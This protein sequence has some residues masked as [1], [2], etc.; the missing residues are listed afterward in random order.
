MAFKTATR[1]RV[2]ARLALVGMSKSGK[3]LL[4]LGIARGIVGPAGKIA[5]IDTENGALSLYAGRY[6]D[7][8]V[9]ELTN[10]SPDQYIRAIEE[11]ARAKYDA[12]IIDS[13]SQEWGS[14]LE[15]VDGVNDKFFTGWKNATPKHNAFIRAIVSAPMHVI[16]TIRQKDEYAT[17]VRDGRSIPVKVGTEPVQR[18]QFEFEF[19]AVCTLDLD[20]NI[21][22]THSA[23]E[24]MPN[25]TL[26][27]SSTDPLA[28]GADIKKWLDQG[29]EDWTPP[30]FKKS[31]M[32]PSA[33]GM[34]EIVSDGIER[35]T[36]IALMNTGLAYNKATKK[37]AKELQKELTGKTSP[38][39]LTEEEG[40]RVV[41]AMKEAIENV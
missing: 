27:P 31:F 29:D 37:Q 32:I 33:T 4:S 34:K 6:G 36:Y 22:V 30:V 24:F 25:G 18:K 12:L 8:D 23:I 2:K 5:A 15:I 7:F 20:H 35:D 38:A 3:S 16:V 28:L 19:N 14:V 10:T 26:I 1:K 41:Q 17:E 11:A 40:E 21:R 13:C 39:E 9:Q